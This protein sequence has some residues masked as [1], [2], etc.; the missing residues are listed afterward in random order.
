MLNILVPM[1]GAG[2][3]FQQAGY[4][5]PKPFIDVNGE[6]MIALVAKNLK[7]KHRKD[8]NFIFI[9]QEEHCEKYDLEN[10]LR[11]AIGDKFTIVK[12]KG[13]TQGAA[14]SALMARN[15]IESD[16]ELIIANSDQF[17]EQKAMDDF[18]KKCTPTFSGVIMTFESTHPKWSYVRLD[19]GGIVLE[20]AEKKVISNNA[21]A[22]IYYFNRGRDFVWAVDNMIQKDI[23]TNGEFYIAPSFNELR[24]GGRNIITY[25]IESKNMHGLGDPE[26]LTKYLSKSNK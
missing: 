6:A 10:V 19:S 1:S 5:F 25:E 11:Q 2:S 15:L 13:I 24:L 18:L 7:P 26:S 20:V 8:Y 9:A 14:C 4:T 12:V 16:D 17:I 22:G 23:R 21:T 3:R